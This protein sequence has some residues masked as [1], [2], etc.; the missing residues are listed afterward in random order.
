MADGESG[1]CAPLFVPRMPVMYGM[2]RPRWFV[3]VACG[4]S[5]CLPV[6]PIIGVRAGC[7][8]PPGNGSHRN[9]CNQSGIG[10][11]LPNEHCSGCRLSA[12]ADIAIIPLAV[13]FVVIRDKKEGNRRRPRFIKGTAL[14]FLRSQASLAA[15]MWVVP[16]ATMAKLPG[17]AGGRSITARRPMRAPDGL[18]VAACKRRVVQS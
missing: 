2:V 11:G 12:T 6:L 16:P 18:A 8:K 7:R 4:P 3:F 17:D 15:R 1:M 14:I 5:W 10:G 9:P 13:A